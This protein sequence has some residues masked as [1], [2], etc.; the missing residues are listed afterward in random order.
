[1]LLS[2][3]DLSEGSGEVLAMCFDEPIVEVERVARVWRWGSEL[4]RVD[5]MHTHEAA[6]SSTKLKPSLDRVSDSRV[7]HREQCHPRVVVDQLPTVQLSAHSE[8]VANLSKSVA[9]TI[10][11]EPSVNCFNV[12]PRRHGLV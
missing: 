10:S 12:T 9:V 6:H 5:P 7:H 4:A 1:M 2:V 8:S 3:L 11:L